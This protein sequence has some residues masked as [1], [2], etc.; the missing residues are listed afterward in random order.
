MTYIRRIYHPFLLA[1]PCLHTTAAGSHMLWTH[2]QPDC[3]QGPADNAV[4]D[5]AVIIPSLASLPEAASALEALINK[6]GGLLLPLHHCL[7]TGP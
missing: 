1:Q 2:Q 5:A 7:S 3:S 6:Q 4:L